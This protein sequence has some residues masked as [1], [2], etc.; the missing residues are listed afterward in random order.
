MLNLIL[1]SDQLV[2]DCSAIDQ[3]LAEML[4]ARGG[5]NRIAYV[6]SGPEPDRSFFLAARSYY[7]RYGLDL[8]LFFDLDEPHPEEAVAALFASDAIHLSGGH[9]GGFLERLK[10]SGMRAP[11]RDFALSGG[12]LIGVSAGAILM[13]PTIAT[14]ALFIGERP[15]DITDGAALDLTPFE[16][17][18]HLGDDESYLPALLRYSLST[19]RPILACNDGDGI[20]VSGGRIECFGE[21]LWISGGAVRTPDDVNLDG[22]SLSKA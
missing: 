13:A 4:R 6:A 5:G 9:T 1:Y 7:G 16:F 22:F 14:D 12:V 11:L 18:P 3:R 21:P 19:S 8:G 17:F 2:P 10:R 15:E 20:V